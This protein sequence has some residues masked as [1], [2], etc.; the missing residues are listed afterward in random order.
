MADPTF[1]TSTILTI[2]GSGVVGVMMTMI[3]FFIKSY[4]TSR[5]KKSENADTERK[6]FV[7]TLN[8]TKLQLAKMEGTSETGHAKMYIHF[9]H[10]E[11]IVESCVKENNKLAGKLEQNTE[12]V[13]RNNN[14]LDHLSRQ[15]KRLFTIVLPIEH[16]VA[17][18]KAEIKIL[19]TGTNPA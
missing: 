2:L 11:S 3:G 17:A 14:L 12:V 15:C 5:D 10:L 1:N 4:F 8:D 19:K 13:E 18:I 6:E 16:D 9:Q 7:A